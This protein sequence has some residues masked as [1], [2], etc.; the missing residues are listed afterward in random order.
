[1]TFNGG[2]D[3]VLQLQNIRGRGSAAVDDRQRVLRRDPGVPQAVAFL[4]AA[5]LDKPC[6]RYL[7]VWRIDRKFRH[8]SVK[9]V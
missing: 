3:R 6:G 1:M 8:L 9:T 4:K 2:L 5:M 7:H